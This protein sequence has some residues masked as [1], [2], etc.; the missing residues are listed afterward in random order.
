LTKN[1]LKVSESAHWE[2][3][4]NFKVRYMTCSMQVVRDEFCG[5]ML[6]GVHASQA[7]KRYICV[8]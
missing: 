6:A 8:K 4:S 2:K 3:C 5:H 1:S 7:L